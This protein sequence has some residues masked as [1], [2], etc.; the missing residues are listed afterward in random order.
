[1]TT[2]ASPENHGREATGTKR[3]SAAARAKE[4]LSDVDYPEDLLVWRRAQRSPSTVSTTR[5]SVIIPTL[6]EA[7]CLPQTFRSL[8]DAANLEVIVVDGG[9]NDGTADVAERA[10]AR[11]LRLPPG[12]ALQ[13]NAGAA[14]ARGSVLLFLHADTR[15]P[16]GFFSA[17]EAEMRKPGVVGGAFRLRIDAPGWP[18]RI[19]EGAVHIR[20]CVL[21]VPYGDQGIFVRKETFQELGGFAM[22]PIMEDVDFI[23]RLRRLGR[24]RIVPLSATTSG[25]RWQELGPWKTTWINQKIVFGYCIGISAQRLADWYHRAR[26]PENH[27][28]TGHPMPGDGR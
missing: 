2:T 8:P 25:R 5:I 14:A 22:L 9:S 17:V 3:Y 11:V 20:S 10:G 12:R 15:L 16:R 23:R 27:P 7:G 13:M 18:L 6:N 24:I 28:L 26:R 4:T 19:I 21:Q 1:M